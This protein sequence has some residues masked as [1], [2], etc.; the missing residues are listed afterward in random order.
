MKT[1]LSSLKKE[2]S[3]LTDIRYLKKELSR[4]AGD[5]RKEVRKF[6]VHV[7]LTPQAKERLEHLEARFNEVL[8]ALR[9][10]QKQV[11]SNLDR[12]VTMVRKKT[13]TSRAARGSKKSTGRKKTVRKTSTKTSRK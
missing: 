6:D 10:L 12:F 4:I 13:N 1:D 9:D 2:L 3:R 8:K 7:H 5:V 11:D